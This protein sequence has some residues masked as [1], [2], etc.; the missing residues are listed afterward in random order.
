[1]SQNLS[2]W[3]AVKKLCDNLA[4]EFFRPEHKRPMLTLLK[5]QRP[6]LY[7]ALIKEDGH[8]RIPHTLAE[9]ARKPN[10]PSAK[11]ALLKKQINAAHQALPIIEPIIQNRARKIGWGLGITGAAAALGALFINRYGKSEQEEKSDKEDTSHEDAKQGGWQTKWAGILTYLGIHTGYCTATDFLNPPINTL[12]NGW[13]RWLIP[14]CGHDHSDGHVHDPYSGDH[15]HEVKGSRLERS[16]KSLKNAFG[17]KRFK[18]YAAG[19]FIGDF[20]AIPA[21]M[22]EEKLFP[23]FVAGLRRV[24]EPIIGPVFRWGVGRDSKSWAQKNHLAD[25]APEVKARADKL[26]KY[27]IDHFPEAV[28]WTGNALVLNTAYQMWKDK[29]H[30]PFPN[31]LL[32]HSTSILSGVLVT[33]GVVVAARALMPDRMHRFEEAVTKNITLPL[34]LGAGRAIGIDQKTME[35]AA[36]E[37]V[38]HAG[39]EWAERVKK[40]EPRV[41][42]V[43]DSPDQCLQDR[44]RRV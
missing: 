17:W 16:W 35:N 29:S 6:E 37:Q 41:E 42:R 18:D 24:S 30:M 3:E 10:Q 33:A 44:R 22:I 28:L 7:H 25:D 19:E 2:D 20:G 13:L 14:G 11:P 1:M 34:T 32:L 40:G 12:T 9:F 21:T 36:R 23:D 15:H 26:Y 27:E 5:E 39:G 4:Y 38:E 8:L 43:S 31:K